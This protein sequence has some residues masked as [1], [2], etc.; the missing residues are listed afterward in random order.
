MFTGLIADL[1]SVTA[2][3]KDGEGAT[4]A[5]SSRLAGEIGEGD[6]VAVNGV[7]LTATDV[8]T[9]GF[10]AQAMNETLAR[11]SLG[12]LGVGSPVNLELALRAADR[13]G[14]HVVQGHVDGVGSVRSVREEG[15]SRVIEIDLEPHLLRYLV[16]KGSVAIDGVSLTVSALDDRGFAVSLIPETLSR[17]NLGRIGEGAVVNIEVDILAKHVE[18]L[19]DQRHYSKEPV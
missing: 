11:S 16:E 9:G 4:L 2:L 10:R 6:S 3:E 14:G 18:R 15:F 12:T 19:L 8:D 13:L 5:I 1:G 7:C 17:T